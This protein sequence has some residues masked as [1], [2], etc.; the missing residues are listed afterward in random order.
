MTAFCKS[1]RGSVAIMAVMIL[2]VLGGLMAAAS[3]MI[4]N[5]VKMNM[6]NRDTIEAQYAAEA[7]AKVGIAAIYGKKEEWSWL[8]KPINLIPDNARATYMV[9]IVD[10]TG[11]APT[12]ALTPGE[13]Y[14]ITSTGTVNGSI[15]KVSAKVTAGGSSSVVRYA[16]YSGSSMRII[17]GTVTGDIAATGTLTIGNGMTVDGSATVTTGTLTDPQK[18]DVAGKT[19]GGLT[20]VTSIGTLDV[21]SLMQYGATFP[22]M[23]TL[24]TVH[25]YGQALPRPAGGSATI[26][27]TGAYDYS[28]NPTSG[29]YYYDSNLADW[30]QYT[31]NV[32]SGQK[33]FIYINGDYTVGMPITGAGDVTIYATGN[34]TVHKNISGNN[35]N[36]Y[37]GKV[38]TLSQNT[39]SGN[40]ITLQSAGDFYISGGNVAANTG[41]TVD[42]ISGN[43]LDMG[44]GSVVGSVVT[45]KAKTASAGKNSSSGLHGVNINAGYPTNKTYIYVD[46]NVN[47]ASGTVGGLSMIVSMGSVN[48]HGT[49]SSA[50]IIA[51]EDIEA[52]AGSS[53]GLYAN[54]SIYIHGANVAYSSSDFSKLVTETSTTAFSIDSWGTP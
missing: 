53:G 33:V 8:K 43:N 2:L 18:Q 39:I 11:A 26:N 17:S 30:W 20:E 31:Y 32:A 38:I 4:I 34:I 44:A 48:L 9:E 45:M 16:S 50:I 24:S 15:K 54:G 40:K 19:T 36:L 12:A 27:L 5:E 51:N 47:M 14:T 37:A 35:V 29:V 13:K 6:V 41:G 21:A 28:S 23:P 10:S 7:G 52:A 25:S 42:I 1:R 49:Q 22:V 46:G 3:P